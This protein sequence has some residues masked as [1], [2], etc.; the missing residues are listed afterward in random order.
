MATSSLRATA[1]IP[2]LRDRPLFA[3]RTHQRVSSLSGW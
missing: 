2:I 3:N 1:T